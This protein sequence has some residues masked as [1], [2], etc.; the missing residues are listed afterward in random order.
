MKNTK[1]GK[2]AF[3]SLLEIKRNAVTFFNR[4]IFSVILWVDGIMNL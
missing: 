3:N 2:N 4:K 1:R